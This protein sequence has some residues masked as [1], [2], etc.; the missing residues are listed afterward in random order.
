MVAITAA[1]RVFSSRLA[2]ASRRTSF[3]GRFSPWIP[4]S[5]WC[6]SDPSQ[7]QQQ[8]QQQ[9]QRRWV[10]EEAKAHRNIGISAHI[11]R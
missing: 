11:D 10:S 3:G 5:L 2:S 7:Q 1:A 4:P 6:Y 9:Q 8:Q